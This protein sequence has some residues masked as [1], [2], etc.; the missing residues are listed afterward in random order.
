M[1]STMKA[2]R[3]H[4]RASTLIKPFLTKLPEPNPQ[5]ETIKREVLSYVN[6]NF[7][8]VRMKQQI[9]NQVFNWSKKITQNSTQS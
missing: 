4:K 9:R 6:S 3:T 5:E 7:S 2:K 8:D 1:A